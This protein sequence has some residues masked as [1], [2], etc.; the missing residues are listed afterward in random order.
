MLLYVSPLQP[1]TMI[2][3]YLSIHCWSDSSHLC[4]CCQPVSAATTMWPAQA[5]ALLPLRVYKSSPHALYVRLL[6]HICGGSLQVS[7]LKRHNNSEI[8]YTVRREF[9]FYFRRREAANYI[10]L[11]RRQAS[12]SVRLGVASGVF[13]GL[14]AGG[15]REDEIM[16]VRLAVCRPS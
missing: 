10:C 5:P 14:Q 16:Q 3:N 7:A 11:Q 9:G 15:T 4:T 8:F 13:T 6:P 12:Q 1:Y 2:V